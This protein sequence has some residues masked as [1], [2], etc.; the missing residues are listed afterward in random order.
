M[1]NDEQLKANGYQFVDDES[2]EDIPKKPSINTQKL[3][4]DRHS[5][6]DDEPEKHNSKKFDLDFGDNPKPI[7]NTPSKKQQD[8]LGF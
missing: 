6:Y 2:P 1:L 3:L 7:S 5:N 4:E 8:G